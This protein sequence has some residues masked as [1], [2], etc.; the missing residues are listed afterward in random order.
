MGL[1]SSAIAGLSERLAQIIKIH[2]DPQSGTPYWTEF[3]ARLGFDPRERIKSI[4]DLACFGLM[5]RSILLGRPIS[6]F[7]PKSLAIHPEKLLLAQTGGTLGDPVWTA[8]S[9]EDYHD[10]FVQPFV[11]AARHVGFPAAGTWLYV[12]P[13]GP[14]VIGRAARSIARAT[15]AMEPFTVDFDSRWAKKLPP[16]SFAADRYLSHIVEQAMSVTQVQPITHLFSTPPILEALGKAMTDSQRA[17]IRGVHYG[18]MSIA[19][20]MLSHLK[21]DVFPKAVHL[22]GY[23]NTLIGCCMELDA[24]AGRQLRYFPWGCRVVFGVLP[25]GKDECTSIMRK[26]GTAGRCVI[27]CLDPSM[28]LINY[29]ERDE[30]ELVSPQIDSP[31]QFCLPGVLNPK[32]IKRDDCVP[33]VGLY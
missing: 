9:V 19:A 5:D 26:P 18:G 23:G 29:V 11:D 33:L 10:A 6:D 20:D 15:G 8:Y 12:G 17:E 3:A 16:Q 27:T 1:N 14:H 7:I 30:V 21:R 13:T 31:P 25:P 22:S 32:P 2:F 28:L 24:A 4:D